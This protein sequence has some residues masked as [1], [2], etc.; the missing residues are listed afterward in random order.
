M[1]GPERLRKVRPAK[2]LPPSFVRE[3][4][5]CVIL[6]AEHRAAGGLA[7]CP[8]LEAV[9]IEQRLNGLMVQWI[10]LARKLSTLGAVA[11]GSLRFP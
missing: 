8:S 7:A 6:H 11:G 4:E 5:E 10:S 3:D 9:E 2:R 1:P